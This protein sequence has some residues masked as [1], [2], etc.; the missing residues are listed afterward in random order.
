MGITVE[1]PSGLKGE[2]KKP[3]VRDVNEL[4]KGASTIDSY[5]K[6]LAGCWERTSDRGI[7]SW[8]GEP[9]NVPW[10]DVLSGDRFYLLLKIREVLYGPL[11]TFRV[12]CRSCGRPFNWTLDL[13]K[14]IDIRPLS[15]EARAV[16]ITKEKVFTTATLTGAEVKFRA[17]TGRVEKG[18]SDNEEPMIR[19]VLPRI[20]LLDGKSG[21]KAIREVLLDMD[22]DVF[23]DLQAKMDVTECGPDSSVMVKCTNCGATAAVDLPFDRTFFFPRSAT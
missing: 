1:C 7:Y 18:I 13:V 10:L 22:Q 5:S 8:D 12:S 6:L 3:K 17:G 2:I 4:R 23:D 16:L 14:D 20:V 15:D 9:N 11:Y 21:D 19:F